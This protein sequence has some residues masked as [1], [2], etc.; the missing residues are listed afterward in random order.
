MSRKVAIIDTSLMCCWLKVPGRQTAGSAPDLWD[1]DRSSTA[2]DAALADG[3]QLVFP[4]TT[5]IET[6]NFVA[7]ASEHRHEAA[8]RLSQTLLSALKG[9]QP[10]TPFADQVSMLGAST[11]IDMCHNWP[12]AAA[13]KVSMG[14]YLITRVADYYSLTGMMVMIL[15]SDAA[16]R[17]HVPQAPKKLPR[18]RKGMG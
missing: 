18:R 16:L 3:Y 15:S 2:I 6:G 10:W 17:A 13:R 7:N 14:D 9:N 11:L 1:Y 4:L 5:L 8:T 12:V